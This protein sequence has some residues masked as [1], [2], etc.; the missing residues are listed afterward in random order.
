MPKT[1]GE[2][3][4][5]SLKKSPSQSKSNYADPPI[6]LLQTVCPETW[7]LYEVLGCGTHLE[8]LAFVLEELTS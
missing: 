8:D 1:F 4:T 2:Q 6:H 3:T 7:A 5:G